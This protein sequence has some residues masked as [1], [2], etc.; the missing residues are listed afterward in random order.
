MRLFIVSFLLLLG[1][2]SVFAQKKMQDVVYLK[3][4]SI[5]RGQLVNTEN[6]ATISILITGNNLLVFDA[7]EV[8]KI[9]AEPKRTAPE[10]KKTGFANTTELGLL[11]GGNNSSPALSLITINGYTFNPYLT[12]GVGVGIQ[13][14]WD[15]YQGNG[16]YYYNGTGKI[17]PLFAD[18]RGD[19]LPKSRITPVYYVRA[20]YGFA[21]SPNEATN[22]KGGVMLGAGAGFKIRGSENIGWFLSVGYNYQKN[23]SEYPIWDGSA[24]KTDLTLRRIALQTGI[25]F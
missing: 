7:A 14:W 2:I 17:F 8:D 9:T 24:I 22:S 10:I 12:V 13:F 5:L 21:T 23:Y 4:G 16:W 20:G 3:N 1:S 6:T 18:I 15:M 25:S 11:A 19:V